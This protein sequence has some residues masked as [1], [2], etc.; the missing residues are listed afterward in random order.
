MKRKNIA[1]VLGVLALSFSAAASPAQAHDGRDSHDG[2]HYSYHNA[3]PPQGHVVPQNRIVY[4]PYA[5]HQRLPDNVVVYRAPQDWVYRLPPLPRN[6]DYY[7]AGRDIIVMDPYSRIVIDI[8][9]NAAPS[10]DVIYWH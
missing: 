1:I 3:P 2:H 5:R 6:A 10:R 8:L 4:V 7:V 9:Q